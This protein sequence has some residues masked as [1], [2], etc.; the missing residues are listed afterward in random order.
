MVTVMTVKYGLFLK[1]VTHSILSVPFCRGAAW[2]SC[3]ECPSASPTRPR[4]QS[5]PRPDQIVAQLGE[6]Y[7]DLSAAGKLRILTGASKTTG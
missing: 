1:G 5:S 6:I 2:T 3:I 7:S 4:G